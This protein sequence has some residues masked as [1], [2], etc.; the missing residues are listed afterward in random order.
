M[1][2]QHVSI[3]SRYAVEYKRDSLGGFIICGIAYNGK[4]LH[5]ADVPVWA[6]AHFRF[7]GRFDSD[8]F[9]IDYLHKRGPFEPVLDSTRRE[10][11]KF[12]LSNKEQII[13]LCRKLI[14]KEML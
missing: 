13:E 5:W 4:I 1:I 10:V 14:V 8:G 2:T 3:N 12:Y 11:L 6:E 9:L 7:S